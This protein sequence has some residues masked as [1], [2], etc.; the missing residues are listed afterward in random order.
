MAIS[1]ERLRQHGE[2]LLVVLAT[3]LFAAGLCFLPRTVFESGDFVLYW[4][5]TFHFLAESVRA[6]TLP[7]W[8]PHVGLG[9]PFLADMQNA[10]FYPPVYLVCVGQQFGVFLLVW[11]H[12]VLAIMG[13]RR[14]GAVLGAGRWQSYLMGFSFLASGPLTARWLTGQ[15]TYCWGLCFVPWLL[16]HA[17][18]TEER[19]QARRLAQYAGCLALQFLCGHPQV[20]WFSAIGQAVFILTS[21]LRIPVRAAMG[22]AGRRLGQFGVACAWCAGLVAVVLLPMLELIK[23]SNRTQSTADFANSYNMRWADLRF[24]F[25]PWGWGATW[26]IN[27]LVGA[28]LVITG[29]LGLSLV[30][31]RKVR[32]LL[33]VLGIGL[34]IALGDNTPVFGLFY[35]W[36]PG[37]AGFRFQSR[38]ALLVVVALICA[39]GIWLSRPHPRLGA[40]WGNL[41]GIPARYFLIVLAVVQVLDLL[42][43]TWMV[44][45]CIPPTCSLAM[46]VPLEHSF[47]LSLAEALRKE[48]L[49]KPSL[50]PPRVCVP[51]SVVPANAGM[52]HHY[53]SFDANCSL[54][55]RRPWDYLHAML[56]ITPPIEKGSLARQV[57]DHAPFPYRNLSLSVGKDPQ[58]YRLAVAGDP[59]PR[60][61]VVYGA[62]I[63]DYGTGLSRLAQ[64]HDIYRRA[65]LEKVLAA[66]LP[67]ATRLAGNLA[68]IRRFEPNGLLLDVEARTN[69]LLVLAEAWYPG[70]RAEIDGQPGT[71]VAANTW[72][73][74]VPVPA[75]RHQVRLYFH[76]DYLL[77][78]FLISLASL[79]LLVGAVVRRGHAMPS[80]IAEPE[81]AGVPAQPSAEEQCASPG[82]STP[83]SSDPGS[84]SRHRPVLRVLA[85]GAVLASAGLLIRAEIREVRWYRGK[86]AG[87]DALVELRIGDSLR[88]Q[89]RIAEAEPRFSE[90]VRLA[91]RACRLTEYREP[92]QLG[93]LADAYAAAGHFDKAID[94]ARLGREL[95]LA[96]GLKPFADSL[97]GLI[98]S[99]EA[100]RKGQAGDRK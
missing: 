67:E 35:K 38:A 63:A 16:Y 78:G 85:F 6:G 3:G 9:R 61:F 71:C 19:W 86:K 50:P 65:L 59:S 18:R 88:Q 37:Y 28:V 54:F 33:G 39:A 75:G 99:Y 14:L 41:F 51:P 69:G 84:S 92:L 66:P 94:A 13:M 74:A 5:P 15:I 95:A 72:M 32:G 20:F 96:C 21:S 79:G 25:A 56:G 43:G 52:I 100:A 93:A 26:E 34:L 17:V 73:R 45:G 90:A 97:Q 23:E 10:V 70:W 83:T 60:A 68:F 27:L 64:G 89:Y 57:Y 91:E 8:N 31:E 7:L 11:L 12:C 30:R 77:P 47:E 22:D 76:Q 44:K 98:D 53:A 1:G 4:K 55:L 42:Q 49:I 48:D 2:D 81:L 58:Q 87:V 82:H 24:L 29:V 36:L 80:T 40:V 62:Q 46:G